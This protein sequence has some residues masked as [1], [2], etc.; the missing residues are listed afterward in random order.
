MTDKE[1]QAIWELMRFADE[2]EQCQL[3][4]RAEAQDEDEFRPVNG[5]TADLGRSGDD[6]E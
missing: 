2:P 1:R 4:H 6:K 3:V 5:T